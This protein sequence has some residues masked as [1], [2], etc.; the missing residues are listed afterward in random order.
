MPPDPP[1]CPASPFSTPRYRVV[2]H[3]FVQTH[4]GMTPS[5]CHA[6]ESGER[7]IVI[8]APAKLNLGLEVI[9]RRDD[10]FHEIATIFLTI[11]LYDRLTLSPS[12]DLELSC[13]DESLAGEDN[14]A[15]AR[16][17]SPAR[18]DEPS[19]RR[20]HPPPQAHPGRRRSRR[21]VER[22]RRRAPRR[23]RALAT[24]RERRSAP[25]S[26]R[27]SRQRRPLLSPAVA[28]P[29]AAA[30]AICSH[31]CR[32]PPISGSWWS[33]PTCASRPRRP[34]STRASARKTSATARG[35]PPRPPA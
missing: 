4:V 22:R 13:D 8:D 19:C 29:S 32:C 3:H 7:Q 35:S 9:G 23:A 14:L 26:R 16:A 20:P 28:A 2:R 17:S 21:G 25:R 15:S 12:A 6:T 1:G 5:S 30:A 24:G 27:P 18:R 31:R 10:G 33:C 11:D 34:A